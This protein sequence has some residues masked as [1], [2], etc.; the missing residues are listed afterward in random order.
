MGILDN[1]YPKNPVLTNLR[2]V[3][4]A[5]KF[6]EVS[7]VLPFALSQAHNQSLF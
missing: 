6:N 4:I 5:E 1:G 3:E 2:G 7:V